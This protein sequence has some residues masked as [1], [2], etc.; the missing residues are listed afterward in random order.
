[1]LEIPE[2]SPLRE[3]GTQAR[4]RGSGSHIPRERLAARQRRVSQPVKETLPDLPKA[5]KRPVSSPPRWGAAD[6]SFDQEHAY[7]AHIQRMASSSRPSASGTKLRRQNAIRTPLVR[8]RR[9]LAR[10]WRRRLLRKASNVSLHFSKAYLSRNPSFVITPDISAWNM[11]FRKRDLVRKRPRP[12]SWQS[13]RPVK[14]LRGAEALASTPSRHAPA[15]LRNGLAA[16]AAD[17]LISNRKDSSWTKVSLPVQPGYTPKLGADAATG[18]VPGMPNFETIPNEAS[19]KDTEVRGP[20]RRVS[21]PRPPPGTRSPTPSR[22]VRGPRPISLPPMA[23]SSTNRPAIT[24][25]PAPAAMRYSAIITRQ[26]AELR[27][28]AVQ[29]NEAEDPVDVSEAMQFVDAWSTYLRRAIA[30]RAVMRQMLESN[31]PMEMEQ[32]GSSVWS[33]SERDSV[34]S[35]T[36]SILE[37]SF[38]ATPSQT[39]INRT[40][41]DFGSPGP[42]LSTPA[43]PFIEPLRTNKR[44]S[45][46]S[47]FSDMSMGAIEEVERVPTFQSITARYSHLFANHGIREINTAW[48]PDPSS[49]SSPGAKNPGSAGSARNNDE[50]LWMAGRL[51]QNTTNWVPTDEN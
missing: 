42:L 40:E 17:N 49:S 44:V 20:T 46:L 10:F 18:N 28:L 48:Q 14:V 6:C 15:T 19:E 11:K 50:G 38:L 37:Q 5:K 34:S 41:T 3:L 22:G 8:I 39:R 45:H 47:T 31:E 4:Y 33:E 7:E 2:K 27:S 36:P 43:A 21:G 16:Q 51:G 23:V 24:S 29:T 9:A 26:D 12:L 1:M 35:G 32:W 13:A 30:Q 25:A